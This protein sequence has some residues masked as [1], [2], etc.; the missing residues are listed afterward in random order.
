LLFIVVFEA[1]QLKN[2]SAKFGT[3]QPPSKRGRTPGAINRPRM[4]GEMIT[5]YGKSSFKLSDAHQAKVQ[6]AFLW[7]AI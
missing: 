4:P 1:M 2:R 6:V 7:Q 3:L 5:R